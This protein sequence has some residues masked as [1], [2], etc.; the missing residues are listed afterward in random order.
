MNTIHKGEH[1]MKAQKLKALVFY[2]TIIGLENGNRIHPAPKYELVEIEDD[3]SSFYAILGCDTIDFVTKKIGGKYYNVIRD[4]L[5]NF[6]SDI[7]FTMMD[8]NNTQDMIPG[9]III[10]GM[11]DNDGNLTSLSNEDAKHIRKYIN[12]TV[13][14]GQ[15]EGGTR[16]RLSPVIYTNTI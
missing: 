14:R 10:T 9:T 15:E 4:E 5:G 2:E 8:P 7:I 13:R 3:F 16:K 12:Y 1:I 11:A 6:T